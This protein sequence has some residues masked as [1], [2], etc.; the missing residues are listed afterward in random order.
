M[1]LVNLCLTVCLGFFMILF[2]VSF[3]PSN[4]YTWGN[5]AKKP[6]LQRFIL[7]SIVLSAACYLIL[8]TRQVFFPNETRE[9]ILFTIG[10]TIFLVGA[11]LW[12]LSLHL[13]PTR[14]HTVIFT[15]CLSSLGILL[16][17]FHECLLPENALGILFASYLF[18]HVFIMDNVI[19]ASSYRSLFL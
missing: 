1:D 3:L 4:P 14:F 11:L 18:F 6:D 2:Y 8:W 10:N 13:F 16:I 9:K 15:L 19:W 5:T 7:F 12:P 17:L